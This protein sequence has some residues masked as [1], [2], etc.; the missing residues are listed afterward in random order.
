MI[1]IERL[2]KKR[3]NEM[4]CSPVRCVRILSDDEASERSNA[5]NAWMEL[6]EKNSMNTPHV[7]A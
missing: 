1:I 2:K 7:L 6:K 3:L 4:S 5:M